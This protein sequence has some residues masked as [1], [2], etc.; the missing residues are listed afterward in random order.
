MKFGYSLNSWAHYAN[1]ARQDSIER[2]MKVISVAGYEGIEMQI[3][4]G[5]MSTLGRPTIIGQVYGS[6]VKFDEY[7]KS[8]GVKQIVAWDY[9]PGAYCDEEDTP[10]RDTTDP[11]QHDDIAAAV[12]QFAQALQS[13]KG[14]VL[15]VRVM[16]SYWTM[17]PVTDE[18]ILSA[19]ACMNK[20]GAVTAKYGV[21]AAIDIDWF[22]AANSE[23]AIDLLMANTDPALVGLVVDA[24]ELTMVE[25][26]PVA[27]V[28]KYAD[29]IALIRLEQI[30]QVDTRK[31]YA[32]FVA[33]DILNTGG[34]TAIDRW[35]W[36]IDNPEGH[37]LVDV[38]GVVKAAKANGYDGWVITE[39][40]QTIDPW[41]SCLFS[42][43]YVNKVLKNI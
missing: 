40:K 3:G 43:W 7:I 33:E 42:A 2:N 17:A 4:T 13:V 5:R 23:H 37:N 21:K 19:A 26:D 36:E 20:I 35:Y 39:C 38:E 16:N 27:I 31:E 8:L 34:E 28:N 32:G 25:I 11:A 41:E 6:F 30:A 24:A 1:N 9:N 29:R 14:T 18:K 10:G 15:P 22:C 12:E